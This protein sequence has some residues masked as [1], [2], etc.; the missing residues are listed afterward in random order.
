MSG[1]DAGLAHSDDSGGDG[2]HP[3]DH[4][5][6]AFHATLK[7]YLT[8]L[9]LAAILTVIPFWLV[10]GKVLSSSGATIA[11]ILTLAVVQIVVHVIYFLHLSTKSERGWSFLALIFTLVLVVIA[12]AGSLWVMYHLNQNM[13][14]VSAEQMRNMP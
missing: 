3:S 10:M 5:E 4:G 1:T 13:M 14:P 6:G 8:G 2:S 11:I 12:L 7:D 9:M